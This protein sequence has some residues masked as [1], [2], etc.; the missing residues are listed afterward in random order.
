[1]SLPLRADRGSIT[2][3]RSPRQPG[4]LHGT[5]LQRASRGTPR[6]R[7]GHGLGLIKYSSH[8]CLKVEP[9]NAGDPSRAIPVPL[10]ERSLPEHRPHD[11]RPGHGYHLSVRAVGANALATATAVRARIDELKPYF[12]HGLQVVYPYDITPFVKISITEVVKTLFEGI[13]ARCHPGILAPQ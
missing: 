4:N 3:G 10:R 7:L 8:C 5:Q 1:M 2:L 13:A 6:E 11:L 9:P 12:P